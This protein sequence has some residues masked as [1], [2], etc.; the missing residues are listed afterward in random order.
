MKV[1][2]IMPFLQNPS[3]IQSMFFSPS[4]PRHHC[5]VS[6]LPPPSSSSSPQPPPSILSLAQRATHST[7]IWAT[8]RRVPTK[9]PRNI[10]PSTTFRI[11]ESTLDRTVGGDRL[12][13][14][15]SLVRVGA[16]VSDV[17]SLLCDCEVGERGEGENEGDEK[18][19]HCLLLLGS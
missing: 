5:F 8:Q 18:M 2:A 14:I 1:L 9:R 15:D 7:I 11:K 12:A 3:G 17:F 4:L 10:R 19:L 13:A 16:G 6:T